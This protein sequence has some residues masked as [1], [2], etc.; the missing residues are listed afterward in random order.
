MSYTCQCPCG[1]TQFEILGE[2]ITR[3]YC[4]C[5]ICQQ[6]YNGPFVDVT[7]FKLDEVVLPE[8]H[9]ISFA[10]YK[11]FGAVDRGHCPSC[12]NPILSK[13]GEGEKGFAFVAVKNYVNP[14]ALPV[15]EMHVFYGTRIADSIDDLPKYKNAITSR[16]AFIKRMI[17]SGSSKAA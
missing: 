6:Q 15:A 8:N 9:A 10:K 3:F 5:T 7:L 14:E 1:T 17:G 12:E 11:R 13:L 2:P 16:F 4:H